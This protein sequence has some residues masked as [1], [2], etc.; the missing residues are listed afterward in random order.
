M[1]AQIAAGA[2]AFHD[3]GGWGDI[4][5]SAKELIK[6]MLTV[7]KT[8]R[9]TLDDVLAHP[10]IA[11]PQTGAPPHHLATTIDNMRKF[12]AR[13]KIRAAAL[14]AAWAGGW[15]TGMK[16]LSKVLAAQG[17]LSS[18]DLGALS[19]EFRRVCGGHGT[20]GHVTLEQFREILT[21]IGSALPAD[22]IFAGTCTRERA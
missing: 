4:S 15:T 8:R 17:G 20:G 21:A 10:W 12:N 16:G 9:A 5:A 18:K 11:A 2:F 22:R 3:D 13:R 7:D 19:T 6:R 14:A 1:Y